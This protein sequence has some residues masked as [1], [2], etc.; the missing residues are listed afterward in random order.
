MTVEP[1][2]VFRVVLWYLPAGSETILTRPLTK[3][4]YN[5]LTRFLSGENEDTAVLRLGLKE[6]IRTYG[7]EGCKISERQD[8]IPWSSIKKVTLELV[9][10][11]PT[12]RKRGRPSND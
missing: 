1:K 9:E 11:A 5:E 8:F 10:N 3:A 6:K 2:E 7:R 12:T 4:E